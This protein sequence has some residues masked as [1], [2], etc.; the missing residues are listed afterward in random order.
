M[1]K[2]SPSPFVMDAWKKEYSNC[3]KYED[4]MDWFWKNFDD[5]GYSL[6]LQKYKF[7]HELKVLF[8]IC[9]M[10]GTF[11]QYND[12]LRKWTFGTM[13]VVGDDSKH[14]YEVYGLW[15]TRS[16]DIKYIM[17]ANFEA[18]MYE[19]EKIP[20]PVS[21]ADKAKVFELWCSEG[22]VMGKPVLDYKC[23]K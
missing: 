1:D 18:E 6:W 23:F 9:N 4:A 8:K 7:N 22:D 2:E 5:K 11:L 16:T 20:T 15:L 19:W 17:D 14:E 12:S 21:D 10:C 3:L 13:W